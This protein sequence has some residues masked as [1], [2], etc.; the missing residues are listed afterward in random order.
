MQ[1]EIGFTMLRLLFDKLLESIISHLVTQNNIDIE[2]P[3]F[4]SQQISVVPDLISIGL[5]L[6]DGSDS[7]EENSCQVPKDY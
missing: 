3:K 5:G 6:S 2:I 1:N 4:G 7:D